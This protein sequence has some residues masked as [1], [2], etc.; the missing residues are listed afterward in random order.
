MCRRVNGR[1]ETAARTAKDVSLLES[2]ERALDPDTFLCVR[3]SSSRR[4]LTGTDMTE[5]GT[6]VSR[7]RS[8]SSS[9]TLR[10]A[11]AHCCRC[12]GGSKGGT[13]LYDGRNGALSTTTRCGRRAQASIPSLACARSDSIPAVYCLVCRSDSRVEVEIDGGGWKRPN[14]CAAVQHRVWP[15][16]A[17]CVEAPPL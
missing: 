10:R 13:T 9:R 14:G 6:H 8:T 11:V 5:R 17:P 7:R 4:A 12:A 3:L 1:G 15:S 2:D 16:V